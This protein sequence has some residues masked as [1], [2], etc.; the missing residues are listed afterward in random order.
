MAEKTKIG[1]FE[2]KAYAVKKPLSI[3]STGTFVT[4]SEVMQKPS[5]ALGSL[6]ALDE[7]LQVKLAL[8]RTRLEPEFKLS[9][10]G[11]GTFNKEEV[12]QHIEART[13]VGKQL[14]RAEMNYCNELMAALQATTPI[15]TWPKIP[16]AKTE[17]LPK[18]WEWVPKK[19]WK[20]L[21]SIAL[22]LENTTDQVTTPA[23]NYRIKYVHPVFAARGFTVISL[24]GIHDTRTEF[25][26]VVKNRRVRYISGIG[27]GSPV[28]YTGHLG[29]H[30]LEVGA[31]DP[32]EVK[33]K[34]IHLLSC[35]TAKQLG[36][37]VVTKGDHVYAGYFE[38]FIFVWDDP[39]TPV[40]EQDLFWK[41]DSTW[42]I[43]IAYGA[44]AEAA[45][46]ATIDAY[47]AAIAQVPN[48]VAA[49]Y[50]TWNRNYLRDPVVDA[51]YGERKAR[52]LPWMF[53]PW[54]PFLEF[55][56]SMAG[57]L[58]TKEEEEKEVHAAA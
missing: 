20:F 39:S 55:E 27:H 26:N 30:I 58:I 22:F 36:P 51:A 2:M 10:L 25:V 44:T 18:D 6:F 40:N 5:L 46:T 57:L 43:S 47:N 29:E 4:P 8:E 53:L 56:E 41:A 34:N 14:V 23:A 16:T 49:T 31:Y 7:T 50:L 54:T 28:V 42:D 17:L 45:H 13:E 35:Q 48:T 33:D 52:V 24:E 15:P 12:L 9:I 21:R 19:Y 1:K 3:T 37:D 32:M 38:N 11:I